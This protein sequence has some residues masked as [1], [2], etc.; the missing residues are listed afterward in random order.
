MYKIRFL[1]EHYAKRERNGKTGM[2]QQP[3]HPTGLL[4]SDEVPLGFGMALAQNAKALE[5]FGNMD[6]RQKQRVLYD[7]RHVHSK[8]EMQ[9]VVDRIGG[10]S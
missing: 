9:N 7:A 4:G 2:K 1:A 6:E 5:A 3:E 8:E 10:T